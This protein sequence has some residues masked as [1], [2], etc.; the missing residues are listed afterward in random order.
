MKDIEKLAEILINEKTVGFSFLSPDGKDSVKVRE[1]KNYD[2]L[3]YDIEY[4]EGDMFEIGPT[5]L[6][7]KIIQTN[8]EFNDKQAAGNAVLKLR[9]NKLGISWGSA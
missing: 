4:K 2:F 5:K 6:S 7:D 8:L 3:E 1:C 9:A